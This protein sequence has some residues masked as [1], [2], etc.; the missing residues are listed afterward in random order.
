MARPHHVMQ[1]AEGAAMAIQLDAMIRVLTPLAKEA[2]RAQDQAV[3]RLVSHLY[4]AH[5]EA[6]GIEGR[7]PVAPPGKGV[8]LGKS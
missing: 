5:R 6:R 1:P 2:Q 3:I 7:T 4:D 8:R